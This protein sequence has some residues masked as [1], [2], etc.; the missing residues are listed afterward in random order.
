MLLTQRP[1][2]LPAVAGHSEGRSVSP[3]RVPDS[4]AALP[5]PKSGPAETLGKPCCGLGFGS[6]LLSVN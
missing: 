4:Q 1:F 2:T 5:S 3:T 6:L